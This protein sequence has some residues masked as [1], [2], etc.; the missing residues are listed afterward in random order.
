MRN[1]K[2]KRETFREKAWYILKPFLMYMVLKTF[3]LYFLALVVPSLPISG[4][5]TWVEDNSY[6]ISAVLNGVSSMIAA[7][8]LLRDFLNEVATEGEVDID[9]SIP[10]QLLDYIK[11]GFWGYGRINGKGL[12]FSAFCGIFF[13]Y[14]LNIVISNVLSF[15]NIAS[16]RY[17]SVETIQY[18]VPLWLGLLL[19]GIISPIA[20]EMVFRGVLYNRIKRFYSIPCSII[21]S[22]LLFGIFHANLPQLIYGTLMGALMAVC[23]EKNKCFAAP[24][25]FHMAANIFAF[26]LYFI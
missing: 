10:R 11:N 21:F 22:A 1:I 20:E 7:G 25:V 9:K 17:E 16:T 5:S 18:S 19:Y 12:V 15:L 24:V 23:Y 6:L 3:I 8:F 4:L 2:Q 26:S 13:A 14:V